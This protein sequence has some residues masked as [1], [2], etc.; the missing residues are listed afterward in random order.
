[1]SN[2]VLCAAT[3]IRQQYPEH[4]RKGAFPGMG[5]GSGSAGKIRGGNI[6]KQCL[7]CVAC[8]SSILYA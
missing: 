3:G 1:M 4:H 2:Q 7:G 6:S 5:S 8:I